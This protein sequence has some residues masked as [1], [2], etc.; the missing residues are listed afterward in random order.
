MD[1]VYSYGVRRGQQEMEQYDWRSRK[2][3]MLP[4]RCAKRVQNYYSPS[5]VLQMTSYFSTASM[6]A[7]D[8][9]GRRVVMRCGGRSAVLD[10]V[11][12][13]EQALP[14]EAVLDTTLTRV[15]S[16]P[17]AERFAWVPVD[18]AVAPVGRFENV[19]VTGPVTAHGLLTAVSDPDF[20]FTW[21]GQAIPWLRG[22][23][24]Y[25]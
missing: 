4:A 13:L 1:A 11:S 20:S 2:S 10:S 24:G 25:S 17:A 16:R 9:E 18:A 3:V 14:A 7:T 12:G 15:L 19:V 21:G 5:G 22:S 6:G 23:G 8:P